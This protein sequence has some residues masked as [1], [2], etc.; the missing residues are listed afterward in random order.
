MVV[1]LVRIPACHAG[2]RG[3]ESRP[4]RHKKRRVPEG[5]RF[6]LSPNFDYSNPRSGFDKSA[7]LPIWTLAKA[8]AGRAQDARVNPVHSATKNAGSRKGPG[9]FCLRI[10]TIR[11]R[12][13]V[14]PNRR[15]RMGTL[16]ERPQGQRQDAAGPSRPLRHKKR[17]VPQGARFFL[18][19]NFNYSNPRAGSTQSPGAI[20]DARRAPAGT[21]AGCRWAIPSTP[22]QKTPGP[23]R[24]PVF[25]SPDFDIRSR[26]KLAGLP[27][28]T[29]A[30]T[31]SACSE[32]TG[33]T[34]ERL[35]G[36]VHGAKAVQGANSHSAPLCSPSGVAAIPG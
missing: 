29:L 13:R 15:E 5:A 7:G 36:I 31:D 12:E 33:S 16:E 21:A 10:S 8:P 18:S 4:L 24:G 2:G 28:L 17:R 6:F 20:G 9:F 35:K 22:P 3:F 1:Q 26:D 11:T 25:L 27:I 30:G 34:L 32:S 19:P 23:A 14:Q